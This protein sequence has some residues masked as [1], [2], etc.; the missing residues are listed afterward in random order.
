MITIVTKPTESVLNI[1]FLKSHLRI[2][3]D[4]ED[5]YLKILIDTA[6]EILEKKIC[7]SI[8]KKKY[9]YSGPPTKE[10]PFQPVIEICDQTENETYFYAG[11]ADSSANVPA[12]IMYAVLQIAKNM[13]ECNDENILESMYVKHIINSYRKMTICL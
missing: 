6:T 11:I 5:E 8:I 4:H 7:I 12:D 9:K 3:H 13:Y 2:E 10:L 1:Q